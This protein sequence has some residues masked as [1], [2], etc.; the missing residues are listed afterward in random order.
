MNVK[1]RAANLND[2]ELIV[3]TRVTLIDE[4]SGLNE[5]EKRNLYESNK[6]YIEN[7]I[8]QDTFIS[9]LAFD[10]NVFV[11]TASACLYAVLPGKKLPKGKNAYIQNVYVLPAYR[12]QGIGKN[13]VS[14]VID[15]AKEKGYTRIN[16][17][18]KKMG[19][20]LFSKCGFQNT[21]NLGLIEM[22]YTCTENNCV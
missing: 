21:E 15:K 18:K 12:R 14:M 11:G 19:I 3:N 7:A 1:Y 16:Q 20:E 9:F 17:K 6:E 13:L 2:V 4:D 22:I 8:K 10:D 5:I